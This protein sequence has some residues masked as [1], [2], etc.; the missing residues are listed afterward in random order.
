MYPQVVHVDLEPSFGDHVGE[1]MVHEHLKSR[2]GVAEPK[3][4]YSRFKEAKRSDER[5]FPLVFL[6]DANVVISPSN[7]KLGEQCGVL[8]VVDQLRDEGERIPIVNSVGIK[9]SVILAWS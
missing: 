4:H 6:S 7:I 9:I 8:H 1:N 5:C 2:R 3:E